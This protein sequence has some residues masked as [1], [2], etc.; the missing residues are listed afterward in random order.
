MAG[1]DGGVRSGRSPEKG[2]AM[3]LRPAHLDPQATDARTIGSGHAGD[4][5]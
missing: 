1:P 2:I 4:E 5:T 3:K